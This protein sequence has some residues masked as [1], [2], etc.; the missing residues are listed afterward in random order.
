MTPQLS[1]VA[2]ALEKNNISC[3]LVSDAKEAKE[4]ALTLIN[5][6]D[7]IGLGGSVSIDQ[8][9]IL[10]YL[11]ENGY[12]LLDRYD[13][14]LGREEV[15]AILKQSATADIFMCS[16][17][18]LTEQ[19]ELVNKDGMGS[20]MGPVIFGP[21][22]VIV[23]C[24]RNKIVRDIPAALKRIELHAAPLNASR[25]EQ[26]VP[27]VATGRCMDCNS[28]ERICCSTIILHQQRQPGRITVI[29]IDEDLGY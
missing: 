18:A 29:I 28:P 12:R 3:I 4:K 21:H 13:S 9:G 17:N 22:K 2:E 11:R 8:I 20:R 16:T 26:N 10:P 27:C 19:G 24:G 25:L 6:N 1:K 23:F 7:T 5:K 15:M 14:S